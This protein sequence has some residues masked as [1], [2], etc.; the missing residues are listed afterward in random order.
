MTKLI[1]VH[2]NVY[3]VKHNDVLMDSLNS[4]VIS[5]KCDE[6]MKKE[7]VLAKINVSEVTHLAFMYHFPGYESLPFFVNPDIPEP[8]EAVPADA[9]PSEMTELMTSTIKSD[10]Y[11]FY[12]NNVI[13][14]INSIKSLC[15]S[16]L[17][18]DIL[19]CSLSMPEYKTEVLQ[20]ESDLNID[21]RYS[22]DL[23]GNPAE[24]ANWVMESELP[25]IVNVRS[26]YFTDNVLTWTGVL[27]TNI[28]AAIKAGGLFVPYISWNA[29][30]KTF[31]LLQNI[32]WTSFVTA[33]G[34][35]ITDFI[36]VNATEIF[37]G[38][39]KTIDLTGVTDWKGLFLSTGTDAVNLP[40]FIKLGMING[41]SLATNAGYI[42]RQDCRRFQVED[43]YNTGL[44]NGAYSGGIAGYRAGYIG[45]GG[46]GKIYRSYN[47][48]TIT[49]AYA[50]GIAGFAV[51][52]SSGILIIEDCYNTGA[53]SGIETGG[54]VGTRAGEA[55]GNIT[56]TNCY[57]T[58]NITT[59][60]SGGICAVYAGFNGG[61]ATVTNCYNTGSLTGR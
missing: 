25:S 22:T 35:N 7:D 54:I 41:T 21:I 36:A 3:D 4:D 5:I 40:R 50:G 1:I 17:I 12:N 59:N 27:N 32:V 29:S 44:V 60:G 51:A 20:I 56:I 33:T 38:N 2:P 42:M 48:G 11:L 47:T 57:N 37:D 13:S 18:V 39:N 28:T 58:G 10:K 26:I 49:G 9:T 46:I 61:R 15:P 55:N 30:T 8:V 34:I 52:I 24:G 14:F 53:V 45:S 43:C 19:S 6:S 31:T 16:Q 23:T